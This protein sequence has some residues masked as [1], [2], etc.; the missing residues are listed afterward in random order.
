[1]RLGWRRGRS[2]R[3]PDKPPLETSVVDAA[4]L[5]LRDAALRGWF[6]N[7][8]GELFRGFAVGPQDVVLDAGCGVGG[9]AAFCARMGARVILADIDP[10]C[11]A[12]SRDLLARINTR[13]DALVTDCDPLALCD[14]SATRIVCT[15]VLEHVA[16]P[17]RVMAELV[18][19]GRPGAQ[20][21]LTVPDPG[22]E[23]LQRRLAPETYWQRPNH[24]RVFERD[25]FTSLIE[26]SGFRIEDRSCYGFY[27][28]M[29]WAMFWTC[30]VPLEAPTHPVLQHWAQSWE[31]L[32]DTPQ[33]LAVKQALDDVL[34]KSQLILARKDV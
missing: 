16:D 11:V 34:P 28:T 21:L 26:M 25:A 10:G 19:V 14:G 3:V 24:V 4:A 5:G 20:Y 15:E 23:E 33:G 7:D 2:T 9:N 29:W 22:G 12:A 1:M 17:S 27:Q 30:N 18:R 32:L 31:A 6:R 8:T 13:T